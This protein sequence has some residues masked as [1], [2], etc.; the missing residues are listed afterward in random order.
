MLN[1]P[2]RKQEAG[3]LLREMHARAQCICHYYL[4]ICHLHLPKE[5]NIP[6]EADLLPLI[7]ALPKDSTLFQHHLVS[8]GDSTSVHGNS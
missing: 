4:Q 1:S 7:C 8:V 2:Q 5:N 6:R 3:W